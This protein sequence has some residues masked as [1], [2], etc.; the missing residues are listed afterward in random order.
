MLCGQPVIGT[1]SATQFSE[2]CKKRCSRKLLEEVA[3]CEGKLRQK[4]A[5]GSGE[6]KLR[7]K[8]AKETSVE[9]LGRK[10][11]SGS[12]KGM[13]Q[14]KLAFQKLQYKIICSIVVL[15]ITN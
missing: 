12:C 3:I 4:A 13:F 9:K 1:L 15:L 6:G 7:R 8:V 2:N 14:N 5:C 10:V 11:A